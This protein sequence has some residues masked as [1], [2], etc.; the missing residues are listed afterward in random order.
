MSI[1]SKPHEMRLAVTLPDPPRGIP[2]CNRCNKENDRQAQRYCRD[3]HAEYMRE[4]RKTHPMGDGQAQRD[5]ARSFAKE[6]L[7]RGHLTQ[8]PCRVCGDK[9]SQMHHPDH[10]LPLMVVWLCRK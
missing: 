7:K 9:N 3:C 10:E 1:R 2:I 5:K 6:Y 4:W 8:E